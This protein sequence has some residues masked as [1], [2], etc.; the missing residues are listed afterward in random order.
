MLGLSGRG[1]QLDERRHLGFG[2]GDSAGDGLGAIQVPRLG[3]RGDQFGERLRLGA[4][5]SD[6]AGDGLSVIDASKPCPHGRQTDRDGLVTDGDCMPVYG[7]LNDGL[8][9]R[10]FLGCD[11]SLSIPDLGEG[12]IV[13]TSGPQEKG[14]PARVAGER[15]QPQDVTG[16]SQHARI[17]VDGVAWRDLRPAAVG[18]GADPVVDSLPVADYLAAQLFFGGDTQGLVR[19][20][21]H[22]RSGISFVPALLRP[23]AGLEAPAEYPAHYGV[24]LVRGNRGER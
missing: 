23:Y 17:A 4:G 21:V 14:V 8:Q 2:C 24:E 20:Q 3:D 18:V 5:I 7:Q 9:V 13:A 10:Y 12:G 16:P 15:R 19:E 6:G 1:G 11:E 22:P